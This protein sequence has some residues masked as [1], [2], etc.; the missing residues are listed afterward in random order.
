M[1]W[2]ND[3]GLAMGALG[4]CA[5]NRL[6]YGVH[7]FGQAHTTDR[8]RSQFREPTHDHW[9]ADQTQHNGRPGVY[10]GVRG[11]WGGMKYGMHKQ[12]RA[13]ELVRGW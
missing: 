4:Y 13:N 1:Y 10:G 11:G 8:K 6:D 7:G 2:T 12:R 5:F 9:H 3:Y